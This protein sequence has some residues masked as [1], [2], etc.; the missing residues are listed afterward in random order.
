VREQ[1]RWGKLVAA[2]HLMLAAWV[3]IVVGGC[4]ETTA[5]LEKLPTQERMYAE[6]LFV[7]AK[8]LGDA[9]AE[10]GRRILVR[11]IYGK[12]DRVQAGRE[13]ILPFFED[14]AP[15]LLKPAGPCSVLAGIAYVSA[16]EGEP[17][18]SLTAV[19]LCQRYHALPL[20]DADALPRVPVQGWER[21]A[22]GIAMGVSDA[23][24]ADVVAALTGVPAAAPAA[25]VEP[26]AAPSSPEPKVTAS[27]DNAE[28][29]SQAQRTPEPAAAGKDA[30]VQGSSKVKKTDAED[31]TDDAEDED[32]QEEQGPAT[33]TEEAPDD[34]KPAPAAEP[35][36]AAPADAPAADASNGDSAPA[37]AAPDQG[38]L[39][40]LAANGLLVRI[41]SLAPP[42]DARV[43]AAVEAIRKRMAD[44]VALEE[45][46]L[47]AILAAHGNRDERIELQKLW[48]PNADV[49]WRLLDFAIG[50]TILKKTY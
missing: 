50:G 18:V 48:N 9:W 43:K 13:D 47:Q 37:A 2:A 8:E 42:E 31:G 44:S 26:D 46:H 29:E 14:T 4:D 33:E 35:A 30:E 3:A 22:D 28:P 16:G 1:R 17:A 38:H 41:W 11:S 21:G 10:A 39:V 6:S 40:Y 23:S 27:E 32:A 49:Y 7:P 15:K 25:A 5:R 45:R 19:Y 36:Q 20:K 24:A 12:K 34:E